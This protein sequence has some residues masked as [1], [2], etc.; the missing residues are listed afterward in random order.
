MT[1]TTPVASNRLALLTD[2]SVLNAPLTF[3][4]LKL[5]ESRTLGYIFHKVH[6]LNP[7][8]KAHGL[9]TITFTGGGNKKYPSS[10]CEDFLVAIQLFIGPEWD[11]R[12]KELKITSAS[13]RDKGETITLTFFEFI[14]HQCT[15]ISGE[16]MNRTQGGKG[17]IQILMK[18]FSELS[19][20]FNIKVQ[21]I[22][23]GEIDLVA[24]YK[25][26]V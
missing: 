8:I 19:T 23:I 14:R 3:E 13:W 7:A 18:A 25:G 22:T 17:E 6:P 26:T 9:E 10:V 15:I 16:T 20:M 12:P 21:H 11:R 1:I 5:F 2:M 24:L 4:R